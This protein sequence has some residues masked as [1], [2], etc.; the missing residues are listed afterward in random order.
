MKQQRHMNHVIKDLR[1]RNI[2][3]RQVDGKIIVRI[4]TDSYQS[5]CKVRKVVGACMEHINYLGAWDAEW[6]K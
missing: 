5:F 1:R 2:D 4:H 6:I 3:A